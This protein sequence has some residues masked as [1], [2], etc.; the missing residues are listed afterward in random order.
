MQR[1]DNNNKAT[2]AATVAAFVNDRDMNVSNGVWLIAL[3][4]AAGARQPARA[5]RIGCIAGIAR[6]IASSLLPLFGSLGRKGQG[7]V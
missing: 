1:R 7:P 3:K 6:R 4:G 2:A 5:A